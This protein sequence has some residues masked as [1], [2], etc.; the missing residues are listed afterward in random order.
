VGVLLAVVAGITAGVAA[1]P[2]IAGVEAIVVDRDFSHRKLGDRI[3]VLRTSEPLGLAEAEQRAATGGFQR[4]AGSSSFGLTADTVWLRFEVAARSGAGGDYLLEVQY[5]HLRE[6]TVFLPGAAAGLQRQSVSLDRPFGERPIESRY[7]TFRLPLEGGSARTVYVRAQTKGSLKVPLHLWE[8]EAHLAATQK[9]GYLIGAYF[10]TL[11]A[12]VLYNLIVF[13]GFRDR[14]YLFYVL[15]TANIGVFAFA[16]NGLSFQYLWPQWPRFDVMFVLASACLTTVTVTQF[17]R[18][19]LD[20]ERHMPRLNRGARGFQIIAALVTA[21]VF[22]GPYRAMV[23]LVILM[24]LAVIVAILA[25]G[26]WLLWR[27]LK[28]ARFFMLAWTFYLVGA[29]INSFNVWG[30]VP[31]N[32]FTDYALQAGSALEMI[33]LSFALADRLRIMRDETERMLESR[34]D[35]RTRELDDALQSLRKANQALRE[36]SLSD[37]LTD[38][39]NR[40]YFDAA[41][42]RE[43]LTAAREQRSLVVLMIDIDHFKSVNDRYGHVFGDGILQRIGH[44]LNGSLRRS[45][46]VLAR[47]GG[48]EFAALLPGADAPGARTVAERMRAAVAALDIRDPQGRSLPVSVSVGVYVAMPDSSSDEPGKAIQHAD[49]ALYRAKSAGR[50]CVDALPGIA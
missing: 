5:P 29:V 7:P 21:A 6:L 17:S 44:V 42:E 36:Q 49:E 40:R 15:A 28:Q 10:G 45:P 2:A 16:F 22:V 34:V 30:L 14:N 48:E 20:L 46:D 47:Y 4:L 26:G 8:R 35:E 50:D 11:G 1:G 39:P 37:A 12:L 27:G 18:R 3:E 31:A 32:L 24:A 43:W 9:R 38:L 33:L 41:L 19:F 25:V 23:Q 13:L